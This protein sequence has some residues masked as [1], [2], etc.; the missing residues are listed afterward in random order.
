MHRTMRTLRPAAAVLTALALAACGGETA[1]EPAD[2]ASSAPATDATGGAASLNDADVTFLQGMVPHHSQATEMAEMVPDR[3]DDPEVNSLADEIVAAQTEEIETMNGLLEQAGEDPVEPM[4]GMDT[5]GMDMSGM[6][7]DEQMGELEGL[8]G[9]PFVQRWTQMMTEHHRGAIESAQ[10]VLAD[11]ENPE[12]ATLAE[13]IIQAQEAE[14]EE[15]E[16]IAA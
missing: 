9:E 2:V 7:S 5:S 10:T 8:E 15:M 16:Q 6:M 4:G 12:V 3:T 1:T 14:I 11:G 13:E